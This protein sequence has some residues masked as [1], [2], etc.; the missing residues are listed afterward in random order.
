MAGRNPVHIFLSEDTGEIIGDKR[1]RPEGT[2]STFPGLTKRDTAPSIRVMASAPAVNPSPSDA[3]SAGAPPVLVEEALV[4]P[5]SCRLDVMLA[6]VPLH[7]IPPPATH[8]G[9][10]AIDWPASLPIPGTAQERAIISALL[11]G[12]S[13]KWKLD[14]F[15]ASRYFDLPRRRQDEIARAASRYGLRLEQACS[16]R[17]QILGSAAPWKLHGCEAT[18]LAQAT[19]F[20]DAV[21][22]FLTARGVVFLTQNGIKAEALASG[23]SLTGLATPDFLLRSELTVNGRSVRWIEVKRFYCTGLVGDLRPWQPGVKAPVQFERYRALHGPGAA[24]LLYGHGRGFR[25]HVHDDVQLLDAEIFRA[26]IKTASE[27]E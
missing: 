23:A 20:E 3:A 12:P 15:E 6:G 25:D 2:R 17:R 27:E 8:G 24:V 26:D 18:Q 11:P 21:G 10:V 16:L 7:R 19:E 13:W 14:S 1:R 22:R 4:E 9:H 5:A